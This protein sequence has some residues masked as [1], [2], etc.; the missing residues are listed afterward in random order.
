MIISFQQIV[1][2]ACFALLLLAAASGIPGSPAWAQFEDPGA[3]LPNNMPRPGR[4]ELP[5]NY[6]DQVI[7]GRGTRGTKYRENLAAMVS[8]QLERYDAACQLSAKQKDQ[9]RLAAQ[10]DVKRLEDTVETLRGEFNVARFDQNKFGVVMQK[11]QQLSVRIR[12][13]IF[14]ESSLLHKVV[15]GIL[16]PEQTAK[17]EQADLDRRKTLY[18]AKIVMFVLQLQN[19]IPILDEQRKK[20][21]TLL[22]EETP[23]PKAYG[24]YA[25][26]VVMYNASKLPEEKMKAIFDDAQWR[27]LEASF[28]KAREMEQHLQ[29]QGLVP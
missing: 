15:P 22:L 28:D 24:S 26:Y 5:E 14:D 27:A 4:F 21:E 10:G 17:Y 1:R 12:N 23:T 16:D 6:F 7:F 20:F 13:G 2:A 11:I 8:L 9:L 18:R 19:G 25:Y 3:D 29:Q